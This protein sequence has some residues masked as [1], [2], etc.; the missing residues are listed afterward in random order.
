MATI[1]HLDNKLDFDMLQA[2]H[3][4]EMRIERTINI[5]RGVGAFI[6][7]IVNILFFGVYQGMF[8]L[9]FQMILILSATFVVFYGYILSVH[10]FS[11]TGYYHKWLKYLTITLDYVMLV[12]KFVALGAERM[13][14][15]ILSV[16]GTESYS[17][18]EYMT[19]T[20]DG[21]IVFILAFVLYNFLSA[22][23]HGKRIIFYSTFLAVICC[24]LM[25]IQAELGEYAIYYTLLLTA[26]SGLL[27]LAISAKFNSLFIKFQRA[28]QKLK[29]SNVSLE[30]KV[31]E[32]TNE[33]SLKNDELNAALDDLATTNKNVM[34]S[35]QY[36][37][38]IQNALLPCEEDLEK[39]PFEHF[40]IWQPRDIVGGDVYYIDY[41]E[42]GFLIVL[43]DCTGH[44]VPGA[45][46]TM[47]ALSA[48]KRI[49]ADEGCL[50]PAKILYQL[51][52][53]IKTSLHQDTGHVSSD[54]GL[55]ASVCYV[56]AD[57]K[58]LTYAGARMP[59][60]YLIN[61]TVT[62]IKGDRHSIGYKK[63]D[64]EFTFTNHKID[65]QEGMSFY[66]YTDGIVDQLGGEKDIPFGHKNLNDL[67]LKS[68]NGSMQKQQNL[69]MEEFEVY[70]GE[71]EMQDDMTVIGFC[72]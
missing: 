21:V 62:T 30:L 3:N 28:A 26:L 66:L 69:I 5:I 17:A 14:T 54:D 57:R 72:V 34:D 51:N 31:A 7:G 45:F 6:I 16:M 1:N 29:E 49:T 35:I 59:L 39:L 44:G 9:N 56:E 58:T 41:F 40:I 13:M 15:A 8:S 32:R 64:L 37:K 67:L 27:T 12:G 23:R 71:N 63:S 4:Q 22:L 25:V 19:L 60:T 11:S 10:Y 48:V 42:T 47:I 65:M 18:Q 68:H 36:A 24:L 61:S 53:A 20:A 33:L 55:D 43:V 50:D 38:R 52:A 70:K 46:I 2:F